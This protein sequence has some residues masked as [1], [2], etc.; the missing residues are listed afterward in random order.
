MCS[1]WSW[2]TKNHL[3]KSGKSEGTLF[4]GTAGMPVLNVPVFQRIC[5][6]TAKQDRLH[7]ELLSQNQQK[8]IL[9]YPA[10]TTLL[11]VSGINHLN[12]SGV[13]TSDF[14]P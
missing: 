6:I 10:V 7:G 5:E 2:N 9:S 13:N 3:E 4:L 8:L 1:C 11:S 14:F 12:G